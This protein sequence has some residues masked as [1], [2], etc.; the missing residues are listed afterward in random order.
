MPAPEEAARAGI[1]HQR[2]YLQCNHEWMERE[3]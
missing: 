1:D 3:A 2:L